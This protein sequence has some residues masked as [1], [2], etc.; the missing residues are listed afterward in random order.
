CEDGQSAA[1]P[2]GWSSCWGLG[3]R[4]DKRSRVALPVVELSAMAGI[5][6][7]AV[8]RRPGGPHTGGARAVAATEAAEADRRLPWELGEA[9]DT[10]PPLRWERRR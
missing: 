1:L 3:G 6:G 9:V 2:A 10:A 7:G 5:P 4:G 8:S